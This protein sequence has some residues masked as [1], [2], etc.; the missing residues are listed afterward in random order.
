MQLT[1]WVWCIENLGLADGFFE[2]DE[3]LRLVVSAIRR[4]RPLL[5]WPMRW[6]PASGSQQG[7]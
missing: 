4:L 1:F 6:K 7:S 3:A 2:C 5:C